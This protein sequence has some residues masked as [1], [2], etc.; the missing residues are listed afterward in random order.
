MSDPDLP[1]LEGV[2]V[3]VVGAGIAGLAAA[4]KLARAGAVVT[5]YE[6]S[7]GPGGRLATREMAVVAPTMGLNISPPA[8]PASRP[9]PPGRAP[10]ARS[11]RGARAARTAGTTGWSA[12]PA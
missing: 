8:S 9:G 5:V 11:R 6:R 12:C 4:R 1:P 10:R 3:A 2:D 7:G